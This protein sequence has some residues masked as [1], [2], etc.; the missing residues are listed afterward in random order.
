VYTCRGLATLQLPAELVFKIASGMDYWPIIDPY[1]VAGHQVQLVDEDHEILYSRY[2]TGIPLIAEREFVFLESRRA[3]KNG[4]YLIIDFSIDDEVSSSVPNH[5]G[6]VR[7]ELVRGG[8][9]ITPI[10]DQSCD[11]GFIVGANPKGWIPLFVVNAFIGEEPLVL[12]KL[13][14]WAIKEGHLSC[15]GNITKQKEVK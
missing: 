14:A 10:D 15:A 7:G 2:T 8:M 12:R 3:L 6:S 4:Q 11:V 9:Q 1:C 13:E 5:P